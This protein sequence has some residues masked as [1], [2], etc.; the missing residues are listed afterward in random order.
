MSFCCLVYLTSRALLGIDMR[1]EYYDLDIP[2]LGDCIPAC[3]RDG[4]LEVTEQHFLPLQLLHCKYEQVLLL[5]INF[6]NAILN[7]S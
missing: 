1:K 7:Y 4:P 6:I 3:T 5:K 2:Q